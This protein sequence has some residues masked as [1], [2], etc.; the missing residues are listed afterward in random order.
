[1]WRFDGLKDDRAP[2]ENFATAYGV[3]EYTWADAVS[4]KVVTDKPLAD[5]TQDDCSN[6]L[7]VMYYNAAGCNQ[8]APGYDL[9]VFNNAMVCGAGTAARMVQQV[10]GVPVDGRIGPQTI[11]AVKAMPPKAFIDAVI[12]ANLA[13]Y[14]A[15]PTARIYLKG[16]T[17]R[18]EAARTLAYAMAGVQS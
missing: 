6:I 14:A 1:M 5:A 16:W 9:V 18:E 15:L 17:I 13:H 2:T 7:R 8:M 11:A 10:A 4:R 12:A 3:T